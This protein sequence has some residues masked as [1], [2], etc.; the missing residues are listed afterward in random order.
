MA[1]KKHRQ[2]NGHFAGVPDKVMCHP[3]YIALS[4]SAKALLFE[5]A[6]QY[7][8]KNNGKLCAIYSQ[9]KPRGWKSEATL[10][11]ALKE[12]IDSNLIL[13]SKIGMYG[14]GGRKPNYY[15]I[16]WQ[17]VY[18]IA[19]FTMDMEPTNTPIR[20]FSIELRAISTPETKLSLNR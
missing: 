12:L 3:D 8:G 18:Q 6:L 19:G 4:Y 16:T 5:F 15:A 20:Q 2:S 17:P 7:R 14:D 10:R 11:K 1:S 13:V 9:L